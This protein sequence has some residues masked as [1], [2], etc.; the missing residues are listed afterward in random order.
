MGALIPRRR[1]DLRLLRTT[2]YSERQPRTTA[3][4]ARCLTSSAFY[5][6]VAIQSNFPAADDPR[7]NFVTFRVYSSD[8]KFTFDG[9]RNKVI[10]VCKAFDKIDAAKLTEDSHFMNDLGLDSLDQVELI[11][12]MEDEFG[13]EIPDAEAEKLLR[14]ADVVKYIAEKKEIHE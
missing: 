11:M 9:I 12:A 14:P 1:F 7:S 3:P 6:T 2:R 13:F 4:V 5:R 8:A 10:E